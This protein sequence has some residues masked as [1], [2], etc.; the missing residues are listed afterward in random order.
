MAL[1]LLDGTAAVVDMTISIGDSAT[2]ASTRTSLRCTLSN[3]DYRFTRSYQTATTLCA[4]ADVVELPGQ[5]QH[6]ITAGRFE[7]QGSLASDLSPMFGATSPASVVLT[8]ATGCTKSG[9]MWLDE[10]SARVQAAQVAMPGS[11]SLRSS[12]GMATSW[13]VT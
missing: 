9:A 5:R 13:V 2:S 7:S 6:F 4:G 3:V 12:G 1:T 8:L 11:I 10:D